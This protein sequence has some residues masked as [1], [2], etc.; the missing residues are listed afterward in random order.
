MERYTVSR[1]IRTAASRPGPTPAANRSAM[2]MRLLAPKM[3]MNT[4]G[5]MTAPSPAEVTA[6][7]EAKARG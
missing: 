4:L 3:I 1:H 7:P 5:G 2:E 6:R